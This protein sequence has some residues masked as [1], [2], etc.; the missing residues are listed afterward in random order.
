MADARGLMI[1]SVKPY[2][3]MKRQARCVW[4]WIS[5]SVW[6]NHEGNG[7]VLRT[8]NSRLFWVPG[9]FGLLILGHSYDKT[10]CTAGPAGRAGGD[11]P[12]E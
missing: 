10:C 11:R 7:V 4:L 12:A 1:I 6:N 3:A 2:V 9:H 8:F 5:V